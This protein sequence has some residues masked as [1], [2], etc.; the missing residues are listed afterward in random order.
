MLEGARGHH[1]LRVPK[2]LVAVA[3]H[4]RRYVAKDVHFGAGSGGVDKP[5]IK[6][7]ELAK[8]V[9][10]QRVVLFCRSTRWIAAMEECRR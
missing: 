8:R 5:L 6:P 2:G 10:G 3:V 9:V 1:V 7:R 4:A